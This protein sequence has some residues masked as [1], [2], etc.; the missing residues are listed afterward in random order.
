MWIRNLLIGNRLALEVSVLLVA[1]S[2]SMIGCESSKDPT[3]D[4]QL[5]WEITP[6]PPSVGEATLHITLRDSTDQLLTGAGVS[7]EG[8]MSHPGMQPVLAD[9]EEV[10]PGVYSAPVDFTMGGDW[11]FII[12]STLPDDRVMERQ[13]NVTG[14]SSKD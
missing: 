9:A 3:S 5:K 6:A 4:I 12:E 1:L 11:F 10:E 14:V 13:I 2:C 7:L 8:N